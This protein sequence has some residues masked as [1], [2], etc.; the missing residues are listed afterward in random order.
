MFSYPSYNLKFQPMKIFSRGNSYMQNEVQNLYFLILL[1]H[2]SIG[3]A[4]VTV[5]LPALY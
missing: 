2:L 1:F 3:K 4:L 5:H